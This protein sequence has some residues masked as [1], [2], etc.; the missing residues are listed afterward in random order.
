MGFSYL[1]AAACQRQLVGFRLIA[2]DRAGMLE[3]TN[4]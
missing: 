4:E 3:D 1:P 2:A